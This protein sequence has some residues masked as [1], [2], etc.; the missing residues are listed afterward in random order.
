M[1]QNIYLSRR[2][3]KAVMSAG[4][5]LKL[6]MFHAHLKMDVLLPQ[7]LLYALHYSY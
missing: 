2:K 6:S 5:L 7:D 3:K 4:S 1:E